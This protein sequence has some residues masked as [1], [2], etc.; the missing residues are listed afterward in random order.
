LVS[1]PLAEDVH[2]LLLVLLQF[3]HIF[4]WLRLTEHLTYFIYHDNLF[5]YNPLMFTQCFYLICIYL[6]YI[7]L[8]IKY[9]LFMLWF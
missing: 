8:F 1:I 3:I 4:I 9:L 6:L 2:Y 5:I 7:F